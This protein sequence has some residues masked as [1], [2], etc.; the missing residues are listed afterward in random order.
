MSSGDTRLI[1]SPSVSPSV[2]WPRRWGIPETSIVP[3]P[4]SARRPSARQRE[5]RPARALVQ[6]KHTAAVERLVG[7]R[8]LC[9]SPSSWPSSRGRSAFEHEIILLNHPPS[10]D[11]SGIPGRRLSEL[12]WQPVELLET[13]AKMCS[14]HDRRCAHSRLRLSGG[15]VAS[16]SAENCGHDEAWPSKKPF[17]DGLLGSRSRL[18]SFFQMDWASQGF[19]QRPPHGGVNREALYPHG[20]PIRPHSGPLWRHCDGMKAAWMS[21]CILVFHVEQVR[22]HLMVLRA[23]ARGQERAFGREEGS[24]AE[25]KRLP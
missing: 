12:S 19:F 8:G 3:L 17:F 10:S 25:R 7:K 14:S 13:R 11:F 18:G 15:A 20:R 9:Q 6:T 16:D 21:G 5:Q 23:T 22:K 2:A 1:S 4:R 24:S